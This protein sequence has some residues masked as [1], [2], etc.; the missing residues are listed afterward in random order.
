MKWS[1]L[2]QRDKYTECTVG[3][4][5]IAKVLWSLN[6]ITEVQ[7]QWQTCS[8]FTFFHSK[9]SS[10]WSVSGKT[11]ISFQFVSS[12]YPLHPYMCEVLLKVYTRAVGSKKNHVWPNFHRG[13]GMVC[14]ARHNLGGSGACST[15]KIL[16]LLRLLLVASQMPISFE[17][18]AS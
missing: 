5:H 14:K 15:R 13:W 12:F 2:Y 8:Y 11:R 18:N 3:N 7:E 4:S 10:W 6:E 16:L 9:C 17:G 1:Y